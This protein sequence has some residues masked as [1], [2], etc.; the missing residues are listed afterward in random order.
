MIEFLCETAEV[1]NGR[2]F[3]PKEGLGS[4]L[5]A[6]NIPGAQLATEDHCV[7]AVEAERLD[8]GGTSRVDVRVAN[9][10]PYVV[11]KVQAFQDRHENKDVYDPLFCLRNWAGGPEQAGRD[12]ARSP[13]AGDSRVAEGMRLLGER[14]AAADMDGPTAY[15]SFYEVEDVEEGD[16]LRQEAVDLCALFLRGF[17]Q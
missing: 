3:R 17:K 15:A 10:L 4:K 11:L 2:I 13:V 12:A 8:G 1:D 9:L 6:L 16:R 5:T 14:F 7:V